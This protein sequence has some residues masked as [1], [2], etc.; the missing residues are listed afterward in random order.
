M[1]SLWPAQAGAQELMEW[2]VAVFKWYCPKPEASA[3]MIKGAG[4]G[5]TKRR[6]GDEVLPD[7]GRINLIC[8]PK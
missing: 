4:R 5:V 6:V 2:R 7:H 3:E 1:V 8:F